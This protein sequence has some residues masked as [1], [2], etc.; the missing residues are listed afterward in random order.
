MKHPSERHRLRAGKNMALL[1][2]LG[3]LVLLFYLI[4]IVRF[5]EQV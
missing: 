2:I 1:A 5:G 3:G 4:T